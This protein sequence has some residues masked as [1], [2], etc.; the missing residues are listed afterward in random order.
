MAIIGFIKAMTINVTKATFN[1]LE[2]SGFVMTAMDDEY[3]DTVLIS[4]SEQ[5]YVDYL[6]E[7]ED[8]ELLLIA[9]EIEDEFGGQWGQIYIWQSD[10][11]DHFDNESKDD[12][13][14][15]EKE[16]NE[17]I[18]QIAA[19]LKRQLKRIKKPNEK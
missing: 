1:K 3:G 19:V 16:I 13:Q 7:T 10:D 2:S 15:F 17:K 5:E 9:R 12:D 18:Q 4:T 6:K 8:E 14:A 11:D